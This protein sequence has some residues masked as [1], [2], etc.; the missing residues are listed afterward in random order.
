MKKSTLPKEPSLLRQVITIHMEQCRRRKAMRLLTEQEWS[1]DFLVLLLVKGA[2]LSNQG[3]R[4]DLTSPG[5]IKMS[6][7]TSDAVKQGSPLD[8][9]GDIFNRLDD[10]AAVNAFIRNH[11]VRR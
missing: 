8:D 1:V 9:D 4:L 3:V 6:I 7:T 11:N 5:G 2:K 10:E